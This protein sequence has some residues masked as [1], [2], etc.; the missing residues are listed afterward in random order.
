MA[1]LVL[2]PCRPSILDLEAIANSLDIANLAHKP[3]TVILNAVAPSGSEADEAEEAIIQLKGEACPVRL[4]NRVA[5][6]RAIVYG[7]A[8][9]EYEPHG[10]AAQEITALHKF[11][12]AHYHIFT[13]SRKRKNDEQVRRRA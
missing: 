9:Q 11:M 6:A 3:A 4:V 5:Y 10:K 8:A 13:P 7:Q 1:D 12:R 2:V